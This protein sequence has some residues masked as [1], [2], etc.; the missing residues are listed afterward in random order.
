MFKSSDGG[1]EGSVVSGWE[2]KIKDDSTNAEVVDVAGGVSLVLAVKD[3]EE[4]SL[5]K[6][7]SMLSNKVLKHGFVDNSAKITHEKLASEI[8]EIIEDPSKIKLAVPRD[9][10]ETCYFPIVQSGGEYD[11][12]VSAQSSEE[13]LKLDV[14]TVSLGARYQM[15]CSNIVRT[16]LV[17]APKPV[18]SAYETLLGMYNACLKVMVPGKPLKAVHAAGVKY[19][20]D[21]KREDLI[22]TLPK[23]LGFGVGIDFRDTNLLLNTKNTVTFRPG[24]VFNLA[25]SFSG[26]KLSANVRS[27]IKAECAV[28]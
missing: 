20:R 24:M 26:L 25:I 1:K 16:I 9:Q 14:I 10:V 28:S 6:K 15:Y 12:K 4:L 23:T 17:N 19:L 27:A 11:F 7:S 5:L 2:A 8:E 3:D 18:N 21:V 22:A 13:N